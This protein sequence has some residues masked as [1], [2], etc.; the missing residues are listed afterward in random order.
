M[1]SYLSF[2]LSSSLKASPP[3]EPDAPV[4]STF[5]FAVSLSSSYVFILDI[6]RSS[7]GLPQSQT[8]KVHSLFLQAHI[9]LLA[10]DEVVQHLDVQRFS[11]FHNLLGDLDVLRAWRRVA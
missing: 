3:I 2:L 11:R 6:F 9:S 4:K 1:A 10:D 8:S 7:H 5:F